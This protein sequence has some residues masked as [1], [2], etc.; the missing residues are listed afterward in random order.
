MTTTADSG[1]HIALAMI[2]QDAMF[3][4]RFANS[5]TAAKEQAIVPIF[6]MHNYICLIIHESYRAL[7]HVAPDLA[8]VLAY[9][10]V[11]AIER[12]RHSV[13]L[14]DDKNKGLADVSADFRRII[15]EHRQEFLNNTWLP[16]ARP[17]ERDLV[18]WRYRGRLVS[19]SHTA[20]FFFAL[21]PRSFKDR[22][23]L[24]PEVQAIA[25]EQGRYIAAATNGLPWEGKSFL[26]TFQKADLTEGEIRAKK[27]YRRSFD[28]ALPEEVKASLT[29]M[30]CALNTVGVLLAD[31]T[32]QDSAITLW[33]LR[34][35]TLHHVL[36]SLRK[37]DEQYGAELRPPDQ[38]LLKEILNAPTSSLVMQAHGGFRN[39][40]VH[41][42]PERRV[43][44]HLSLHAPLY[45]LLDAYFP[46]AEARS[47]RDGL[48]LYTAHVADRMEAWSGG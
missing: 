28:P 34:Y 29:A 33:K 14:F 27:Y 21:P 47:L 37:L 19:T 30:V 39:T 11:P 42:R 22:D 25:V 10:C 5:I 46:A 8:D 15:D 41:Y 7:R 3:L 31:D 43:R 17:L 40:L 4:R 35:V 1:N 38:A 20:S 24:G 26:D 36:S 13:K 12:A 45:G 16:L 32:R 44:K 9:E 48:V 18:L 2:V 23:V 6:C